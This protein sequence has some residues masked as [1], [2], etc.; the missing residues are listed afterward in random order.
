MKLHNIAAILALVSSASHVAAFT[1]TLPSSIKPTGLGSPTQVCPADAAMSTTALA[2]AK[3]KT[4]KGGAKQRAKKKVQMEKKLGASGS[5]VKVTTTTAPQVVAK[6][7][8]DPEIAL[9]LK[10]KYEI[11]GRGMLETRLA[12]E[13]QERVRREAEVALALKQKYEIVGRGMLETRLAN[14]QQ[15]RVRRE[16]E[17]KR[18]A[19]VQDALARQEEIKRKNVETAQRMFETRVILEQKSKAYKAKQQGEINQRALLA[20][21]LGRDARIKE[22]IR[23]REEHYAK[24]K[25]AIAEA[26]RQPKAPEEERKLQ[27]KYAAIEN[28]SEKAFAIKLDLGII[29]LTPDPSDPNYD[30]TYDNEI[31]PDLV[32]LN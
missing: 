25:A 5:T 21:R 17:E 30:D 18:Q 22:A 10:Q 9:A 26:R 14:E 12:N 19:A 28:L 11:V 24:R 20:E 13:Q 31:V 4:K 2:M 6:K 16:E 15:E 27:E 23:V 29:E 32:Y 3:K 7:Q 8:E 1:P